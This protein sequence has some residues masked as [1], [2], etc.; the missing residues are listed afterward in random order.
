VYSFVETENGYYAIDSSRI[1]ENVHYLLSKKS[2]GVYSLLKQKWLLCNRFELN[3]SKCSLIT[4]V[5][6]DVKG[7]FC[8]TNEFISTPSRN[9]PASRERACKHLPVPPNQPIITTSTHV[10][11]PDNG[12]VTPVIPPPSSGARPAG[13]YTGPTVTTARRSA[14]LV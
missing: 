5:K 3:F 4:Y 6:D 12:L 9:H 10:N 14:I 13:Q 8:V 1:S 2:L 7:K 11:P